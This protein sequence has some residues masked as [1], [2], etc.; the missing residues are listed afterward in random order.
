[1]IREYQRTLYTFGNMELPYVFTAE[2]SHYK[3]RTVV[4][5]G[6]V[7]I[8]KPH[9][10]LPGHTRGPE[11]EQGFE[12]AGAMPPDATYLLRAMGLPYS[13]ISNRPAVEEQI[14]YGSLNS[15]IDRLNQTME[16]KG[17]TETGLIKGNLEG[18]DVS[19]M[20]YALGLAIK[21]GPENVKEFLEHIRKQRGEPIRPDEQIT[22]EDLRRL[23][24]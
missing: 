3:D 1:M 23:F 5:K 16:E 9:I 10:V 21:S 7:F 15:V 17:D 2:H 18:T 13:R 19:L 24:G 11:F 20:R 14:E 8:Q 6:M 22:D 12:H 4:R